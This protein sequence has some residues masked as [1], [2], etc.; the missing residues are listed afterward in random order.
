MTNHPKAGGIATFLN[1][2]G[3]LAL[4]GRPPNWPGIDSPHLT[5]AFRAG[6]IEAKVGSSKPMTPLRERSKPLPTKGGDVVTRTVVQS[7]DSYVD[8]D[9]AKKVLVGELIAAHTGYPA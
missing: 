5:E 7:N 8:P 1:A 4:A 9:A 2:L 3:T 6:P